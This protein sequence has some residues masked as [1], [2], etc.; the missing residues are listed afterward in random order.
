M[1]PQAAAALVIVREAL[2]DAWALV[3]PIECLGCGA[4]DRA[5]CRECRSA[6]RAVEPRVVRCDAGVPVPVWVAADYAGPVRSAILALKEHGRLD[7]A[8]ALSPA[9]LAAVDAAARSAAAP[10]GL[11][12]ARI[13]T[14]RLALARRGLDPVDEVLRAARLPSATPLRAVRQWRAGEQK[15]R[16]RVGRLAAA[17]GRYR[18]RRHLHDR[19]LILVDDVV[20]TGATLAAAVAAVREA[21]GEVLACAAIAAPDLRARTIRATL[22]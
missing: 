6:L 4:L 14:T 20:T 18:S 1:H 17:S 15:Q 5:I 10:Q 9:L 3:Q 7:A 11:E 13:P 19:R 16:D 21:G 8:R 2:L 22:R 12:L